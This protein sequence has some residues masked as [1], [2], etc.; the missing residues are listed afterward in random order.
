MALA[1]TSDVSI[2]VY[3]PKSESGNTE[4]YA[5]VYGEDVQVT[6]DNEDYSGS[7][8]VY[9]YTTVT[10]NTE[11]GS[12]TEDEMTV[13]AVTYEDS[14]YVYESVYA[15]TPEG[16]Y[17]STTVSASSSDGYVAES[18]SY[19]D[20]TGKSVD[21]SAYYYE[22]SSGNETYTYT[23]AG[24]TYDDAY[25]N[26]TTNSYTSVSYEVTDGNDTASVTYT[27]VEYDGIKYNET[28]YAYWTGD[29]SS[30]SGAAASEF[31]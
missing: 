9:E 22:Y 20:S 25:N 3:F 12:A 31:E 15:Y 5:E 18:V 1:S 13:S 10:V 19:S 2:D 7:S 21:E 30:G 28:D 4:I 23:Y 16:E 14:S 11:D 6:V 26:E 24:T 17:V 8:Y 29:E 27:E